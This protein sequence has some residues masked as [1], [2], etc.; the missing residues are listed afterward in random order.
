MLPPDRGEVLEREFYVWSERCDAP[1]PPAAPCVCLQP[2]QARLICTAAP[3]RVYARCSYQE[4][5]PQNVA[6]LAYKVNFG[7][8]I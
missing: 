8:Q 1:A 5:I 6:E 3:M 7:L 2:Q 4:D